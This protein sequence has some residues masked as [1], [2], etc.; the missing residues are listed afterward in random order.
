M[1]PRPFSQAFEMRGQVPGVGTADG[2][3]FTAT[4]VPVGGGRH[5]LFL[6]G[7]VRGAIGKGTGDPDEIRIRLDRSDRTPETPPELQ[8]TL[9]E[10]GAA[11]AWEAL[12]PLRRKEYLVWMADARQDQT[13]AARISRIVQTT[14]TEGTPRLE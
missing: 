5:R 3:A 6:R 12:T 9:A 13:R 4:L 1:F 11:A 14:L 8:E 7:A 2:V 10:G